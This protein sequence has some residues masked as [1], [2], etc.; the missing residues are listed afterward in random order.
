VQVSLDY[1]CRSID[2]R[3]LQGTEKKIIS[4]IST[5]SRQVEAGSLFI[6]L[7][8]ERFDGHDFV[9]Q[10]L[11]EGALAAVISK[12]TDK[13]KSCRDDKTLIL[14]EDTLQALQD[15]A[16]SYRRRLNLPLIA[17]TGSVGKT[18]SK[19]LIASCLSSNWKTLKT[20]GNFNN[21]IGLPLTLLQLDESYQVAVVEMGMR[22]R[23]EIKR[24]ATIARPDYAL[25][26]NVEPV[27]LETMG[28]LENIARAKCEVLAQ[29]PTDGFALINGDNNLL[30]KVAGEYSCRKYTFGYNNNCDFQL[31][32]TQRRGSGMNVIMRIQDSKESVYF[33]L[34]T[35][36]LALNILAAVALSSL[37]GINRQSIKNSILSYKPSGNRLHI[38]SLNDGGVVINDTYN[39]N[40]VS[41]AAALET[42]REL[43]L[44]GKYMAVLG[45]MYELGKLEVEGH[46][47][48]G[49][50]AFTTGVDLLVTVGE[51]AEDI[52]RGALEAGMNPQKVQHFSSREES[53]EYLYNVVDN[54]W[55]ILFKASRG[56]QLEIL[57]EDLFASGYLGKKDFEA[58]REVS[59]CRDI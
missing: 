48:V 9:K 8:G 33:P 2:G 34:P 11:D 39:A 49:K 5:D 3:I 19:E 54:S 26:T 25:I 4:G 56:M 35:S 10:A 55:T 15:L 14:V 53:R 13:I 21:D 30:R 43:A 24:L 32:G 27:H 38:I 42:G 59:G 22:A 23:G 7:S 37:L 51:R 28:S 1:I 40:P 36:R 52:A 45:D 50:K 16:A 44:P 58:T 41:M 47:S 46:R 6:A 29:L 57:V 31:L 17:V 20:E 18:T 12:T